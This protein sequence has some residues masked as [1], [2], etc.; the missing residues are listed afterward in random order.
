MEIEIATDAEKRERRS[1]PVLRVQTHCPVQPS[2]ATVKCPERQMS[3]LARDFKDE[4]IG[5]A[6]CRSSAE[7]LERG[8]HYIGIL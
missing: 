5:E 8:C 2:E 6:Q 3:R 4:T 7:L 1:P